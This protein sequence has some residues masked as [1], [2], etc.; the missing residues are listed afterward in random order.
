MAGPV[1]RN[2][3]H[4]SPA[5]R[6]AFIDA[7]LQADLSTFSDGVSYWDKQD[8]IHQG[9][10]NHNGNSFVPWHRELVNRFEALLQQAD[11]DVALPYW[12]WTED[13][14][15]ADDGQGGTV[16]LLSS[17]LMGTASGVVDGPLAALHN[18]GALAGSRDATG[19]FTDPPRQITRA[20]APGAPAVPSD[21]AVLASSNGNPQAQQWTALRIALESAHDTAHVFFGAGSTIFDPH[22][23]FEDPFV[24]LLH[25]NVDR[26][27]AMWQTE[28][29]QEWRLDPDQVYGDQSETADDKGILQTL[30]P[31]DGTVEF[32]APIEPWVGASPSIEVKNSRHPSVVRP[33]CYDT[34]PL[35]VEQ[36]APAPGDPVRFLDVV[37]HLPTAR[38]LRLRV[39][40]CASVTA[41]ASV[42][43]PFT[44]L[45]PSVTSPQPD[46]F[47]ERD[48]L[49]WVLFSP[50][51]AGSSAAGTLTV[52]I[53]ETGDVLTVPVSATVV[54]NPTVG[55][56][57]VLDRSGSMDLPSGLPLKTRMEVLHD[58]APLFVALL[59]DDDGSGVVRFD[60]DAAEAAPVQD[61]GPMIGGAG[62]LAS[63]TAITT[64][65]TNVAGLTAIGD[66][67]EAGAGQ[68]GAVAGDYDSTA[69]IV[70]TDGHET[71]DKTIAAAASSVNSRVF[72]IGLGTADQLN[73]G[74][75][76][77]IANG[78]GGYLLLTGNPGV[79]DQLLLQ[80]YFAQVL[81]GATNSAIVVDPDGFVPVGGQAVVPYDLTAADIRADVLVLGEMARA[82]T[83]ELVAPDGTTL[84]PGAGAAEIVA[85]AYRALRVVPADALAPQAGVGTWKAVLSVD[86]G[87]LDRFIRRLRERIAKLDRDKLGRFLEL[88]LAGIETHGVPYSLTVQARSALRLAVTLSQGSRLP[89]TPGRLR[90]TLTDSGIPLAASAALHAVVTA[91]DGTQRT[92]ALAG[93]EPGVFAA[94]VPTD[95]PGVY[96]VLVRAAGTDLRG[97]PFTRE[98]LRTLAVWARGDEQP[99]LVIDP[100]G[101]PGG[102]D[103][104]RSL[105][106]L[107][108]DDGVRRLL[109]RNE[110][111]AD[112]VARCVKLGCG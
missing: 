37:E 24:F 61:A 28:P 44:L 60:T 39:R 89:G 53:A 23:A 64:T 105:L 50:G 26:L 31:W 10:H 13:P 16:N 85:D 18:G 54:P 17:T 75:L 6:Q 94:E 45:A 51:A 12:D 21:A 108:E 77:D 46:G 103:A 96:R 11:P 72:A 43:G 68:L 79:D 57:L 47:E 83:V 109:E 66:G 91:P 78:T 40:G 34:L 4:L 55:T 92:L 107:L 19:S 14:R 48:L 99:P 76:S 98:E 59:D 110:V 100:A 88:V 32:G 80:K 29:G 58:A 101:G 56:S 86:R 33:P 62:R 38:A 106:C 63:S 35:T 27:F 36:V 42:T 74:A 81:A 3:A 102:L 104:C 87:E 30:Q 49:V 97:T 20:C 41:N 65:A 71:A 93:V 82:L 84:T 22:A 69:T 5:E 67:L 70:F 8:Q 95:G 111:D 1:R 15:A 2:F 52:T 7:L 25:C 90:A 112:R 9:T 73:P